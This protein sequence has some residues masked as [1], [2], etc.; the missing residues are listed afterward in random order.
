MCLLNHKRTS[1]IIMVQHPAIPNM[2][3]EAHFSW[4]LWGICIRLKPNALKASIIYNIL[5]HI[6]WMNFWASWLILIM[7]CSWQNHH[8]F[9]VLWFRWGVWMRKAA[10]DFFSFKSYNWS[11]TDFCV[12]SYGYSYYNGIRR[13]SGVYLFMYLFMFWYLGWTQGA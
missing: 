7:S 3:L 8:L 5:L 11:F 6:M 1:N 4:P 10:I 9:S 12:I 2:F 13:E